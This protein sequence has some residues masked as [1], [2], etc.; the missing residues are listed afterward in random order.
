MIGGPSLVY[1]L[2]NLVHLLQNLVHTS[3]NLVYPEKILV[4]QILELLGPLCYYP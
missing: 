1:P 2:Q 4:H 3:Q